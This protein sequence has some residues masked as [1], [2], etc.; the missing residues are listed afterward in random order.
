VLKFLERDEKYAFKHPDKVPN[1]YVLKM[2]QMFRD[3]RAAK[4]KGSIN[5]INPH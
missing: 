2:A 4:L 5:T 1:R 3:R